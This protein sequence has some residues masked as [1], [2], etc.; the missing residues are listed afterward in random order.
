MSVGTGV[1]PTIATAAPKVVRFGRFKCRDL[2]CPIVRGLGTVANNIDLFSYIRYSQVFRPDGVLRTKPYS[3]GERACAEQVVNVFIHAIT[4]WTIGVPCNIQSTQ[5][6][7]EREVVAAQFPKEDQK[8]RIF[9]KAFQFM[10]RVVAG[11][12]ASC[13][14]ERYRYASFTKKCP[15]NKELSSPMERKPYP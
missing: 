1:Y 5:F 8:S 13:W 7:P 11:I 9:H 4:R 15:E 6:Y 3:S 2:A 10:R 12:L 14:S